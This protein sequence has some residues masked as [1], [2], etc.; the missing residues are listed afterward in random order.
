MWTLGI[1]V[2]RALS[3]VAARVPKRDHDESATSPPRDTVA[4]CCSVRISGLLLKVMC[5]D[6]N[7]QAKADLNLASSECTSVAH[8]HVKSIEAQ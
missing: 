6:D 2:Q 4:V 1:I 7:A 8:T 5:K 3:L